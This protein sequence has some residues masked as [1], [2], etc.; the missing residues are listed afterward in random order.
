M[1]IDGGGWFFFFAK[2]RVVCF[3]W[4]KVDRIF[5]QHF[6][7]YSFCRDTTSTR[8]R[9]LSFTAMGFGNK[10]NVSQSCMTF[11][12]SQGRVYRKIFAA[13]LGHWALKPVHFSEPLW[14]DFHHFP[15]RAAFLIDPNLASGA[16]WPLF[17]AGILNGH[18]RTMW[19]GVWTWEYQAKVLGIS[20]RGE[21]E[22][23][24]E[25]LD[26]IDSWDIDI[27][28]LTALGAASPMASD[29]LQRCVVVPA[30]PGLLMRAVASL[31]VNNLVSGLCPS[32]T[33]AFI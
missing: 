23:V 18:G 27:F 5:A 30:R 25:I 28:G 14:S 20:D 31:I 16:R 15:A 1:P 8:H 10:S 13:L 29:A 2:R 7:W 24:Y 6:D 17:L 22:K 9:R 11:T 12:P 26:H 32:T 33:N 4:I 19:S 21:Q 3:L